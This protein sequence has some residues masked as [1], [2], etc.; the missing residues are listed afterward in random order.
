MAQTT[1]SA[2]SAAIT[3]KMQKTV[4]TNLRAA[5]AWADTA[6]AET[7]DFD[8]G[9]DTLTFANVPDVALNTTQLTEGTRPTPKA[10]TMGTVTVSTQQYGD[11]VS[12]TDLAKVKAPFEIVPIASERVARQAA[13]TLDQVARDIIA[14]GG[15]AKFVNTQTDRADIASTDLAVASDLRKLRATMFK[16]KIKPFADGY[17]RMFISPNVGYDL[18]SDTNTGGWIDV[19]K[20]ATPETLLRGELGRMEGFRIMEVVNA[21]T[22]ASTTTVYANIAVGSTKGWG[23][24]ELQTLT[25]HHVAPGGDH[26]DALA[27]EELVGLTHQAAV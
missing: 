14:A 26:A 9:H 18:R 6:Y 7:G 8:A 20:Y 19:N 12:I 23:C 27:Q 3:F 24:G 21:P 1:A 15:T 4:L 10:L 11:L 13:E 25:T 22:F 5:L 17:Y 2:F 16:N